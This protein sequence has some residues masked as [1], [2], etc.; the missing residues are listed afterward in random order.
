MR[1]MLKIWENLTS[2]FGRKVNLRVQVHGYHM[3]D[4]EVL[5]DL[6]DY[7]GA[8]DPLPLDGDPVKLARAAGR[9]DVWRRIMAHRHLREG[10]VYALL[11]GEPI[12]T[13]QDRYNG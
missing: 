6:A 3:I 4:Q 11:K 2:R 1:A 13:A 10:E 5:A 9:N 7:C 12:A 8:V